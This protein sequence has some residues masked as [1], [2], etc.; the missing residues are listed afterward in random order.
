MPAA[1]AIVMPATAVA[2]ALAAVFFAVAATAPASAAASFPAH[3]VQH[4][5]DLFVGGRTGFY[6]TS[7]EMQGLSCP[8]VIQIDNDGIILYLLHHAL[9]AQAVTVLQWNDRARVHMRGIEV[10][11]R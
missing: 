1:S 3:H 7:F 8:R 10:A 6:D 5:C 9:E 4:T 11:G 2:T